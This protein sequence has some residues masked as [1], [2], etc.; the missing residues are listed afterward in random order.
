MKPEE[1]TR[2]KY[3]AIAPLLNERQ[4]RL[5][6]A[7]EA[8][9]LGYGGISRIHRATGLSR[10]VIS[11]GVKELARSK[12]LLN[13]KRMRQPGGG[14]HRLE[15]KDPG[16]PQA[17]QQQLASATLGDP[18]SDVRWTN[19]S[20]RNLA[21]ALSQMGHPLSHQSVATRLRQLRYSLQ[22]NK[23]NIEG[24]RHPDRHAQYE[25]I[26]ARILDFTEREQPWISVDAKKKKTSATTKILARSGDPKGS[27]NKSRS[28]I[29]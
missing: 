15:V 28:M 3:E 25:Y 16:L 19:K 2:D 18:E 22:G 21:T 6:C 1:K 5:W 26:Q 9:A 27:R 24:Q 7:A 10:P 14:R 8:K 13:L 12:D 23:K 17:L 4:K 11:A 29:S 20:T